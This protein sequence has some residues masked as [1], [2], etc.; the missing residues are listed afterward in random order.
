MRHANLILQKGQRIMKSAYPPQPGHGIKASEASLVKRLMK[1]KFSYLLIS[2]A[3]VWTLIFCYLPM[4]GLVMAFQ[5]FSIFKGFTGSK[6]VGLDNFIEIFTQPNFLK[7]I[8]NTLHYNSVILF[9]GFPFP[10]LLAL[11]FN[12]LKNVFFKKIVQTVSYLPYF[13]SW[14]SVVALFYSFFEMNGPFNDLK[15]MLAGQAIERTNILMNPDNFL[16]IL[17][18]SHLWKNLGWSSVI[19]IAA[20][21]GI[22]PNLYEAATVDG[23]GRF[24]QAMYITIPGILPTV[25]IIFILS[26]SSLVSS[27]FEQV[28]GFQNL[29]TMEQTQVINTLVYKIGIQ[30][31][32]YS[33]ATAFGLAQGVVSFMIVYVANRISRRL[34]NI[35]IW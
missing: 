16:G 20:I 23:C 15:T 24:K 31:G 17:F 22:D 12:E 29:Y 21:A 8:L 27:N 34:S 4:F 5:E 28:F 1:Y 35:G 18:G 25:M 9:L 19:F 3:L 26:T 32:N 10:I 14:I 2:G 33:I 11:L 6:F 30:Q 13:L 7:A